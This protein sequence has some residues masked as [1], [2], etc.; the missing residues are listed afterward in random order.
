MC[1][2]LNQNSKLM[3]VKSARTQYIVTGVWFC[4]VE[5][6]AVSMYYI[7]LDNEPI[8]CLDLCVSSETEPGR[9]RS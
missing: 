8:I 4:V 5:F 3:F 6:L 9:G 7:V 2:V 1:T